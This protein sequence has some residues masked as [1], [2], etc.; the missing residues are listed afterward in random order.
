MTI[1][2]EEIFGSVISILTYKSDRLG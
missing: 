1:A 2:K